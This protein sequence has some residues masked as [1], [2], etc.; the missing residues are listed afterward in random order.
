MIRTR[1]YFDDQLGYYCPSVTSGPIAD[2]ATE[3]FYDLIRDFAQG[4]LRDVIKILTNQLPCGLEG[5]CSY[6]Y[7]SKE[8]ARFGCLYD[9]EGVEMSR[10]KLLELV[11]KWYD[12]SKQHAKEIIIRRDGERFEIEGVDEK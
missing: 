1:F 5:N 11:V 3:L 8:K 9:E 12:L 2:K 10:A 4:S 6:V 7:V